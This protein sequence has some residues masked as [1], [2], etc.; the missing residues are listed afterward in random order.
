MHDRYTR[1]ALR[2]A[3]GWI[4]LHARTIWLVLLGSAPSSRRPKLMVY[5]QLCFIISSLQSRYYN[6]IFD[7][8]KLQCV[9]MFVCVCPKYAHMYAHVFSLGFYGGLPIPGGPFNV[10]H[11]TSFCIEFRV[12][13]AY[14]NTCIVAIMKTD[15][16]IHTKYFS[17]TIRSDQTRMTHLSTCV[18]TYLCLYLACISI[19]SARM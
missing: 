17:N 11:R 18:Y 9:S 5:A 10:P 4:T 8:L 7:M 13:Y 19:R 2:T 15:K 3:L 16:H 14:T 6:I 12:Q 1:T